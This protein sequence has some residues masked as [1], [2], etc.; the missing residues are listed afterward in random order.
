MRGP[1][2]FEL[3]NM[4][5]GHR[6]GDSDTRSR[7]P[8]ASYRTRPGSN[9]LMSSQRHGRRTGTPAAQCGPSP[10][11]AHEP[12]DCPR[13]PG[14]SSL[15]QHFETCL[16][17]LNLRACRS[18]F[19]GCARVAGGGVCL[20]VSSSRN[21]SLATGRT[22]APGPV[23]VGG[24]RPPQLNLVRPIAPDRVTRMT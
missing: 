17:E 9:R 14:R 4:S 8:L 23:K 13:P 18:R 3:R 12:D 11:T 6:Y 21:P 5:L 2:T 19:H 1:S 16:S 22:H 15:D 24:H 20:Q 7:S 10:N